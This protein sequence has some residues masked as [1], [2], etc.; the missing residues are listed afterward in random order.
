MFPEN[1]YNLR[2]KFQ[3]RMEY[4]ED[5]VLGWECR[6]D[7]KIK[8]RL[9]ETDLAPGALGNMMDELSCD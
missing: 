4:P 8:V 6:G 3:H 5:E 1:A 9:E 2:S 7:R